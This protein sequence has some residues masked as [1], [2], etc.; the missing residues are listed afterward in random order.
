MLVSLVVSQIGLV[1]AELS[2]VT[3]ELA[4]LRE[5]RDRLS[6]S[7]LAV[8]SDAQATG[9]ELDKIQALATERERELTETIGQRAKGYIHGHGGSF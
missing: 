5:N 4:K 8:E 3:G 1:G 2:G 6:K 7:T 9:A